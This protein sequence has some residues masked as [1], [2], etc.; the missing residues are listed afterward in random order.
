MYSDELVE[1]SKFFNGGESPVPM[2]DTLEIM[3]MLDAAA[4]SA[5]SGKQEKIK[6]S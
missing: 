1:V 5:V 4:A 6:T 3:A 2:E